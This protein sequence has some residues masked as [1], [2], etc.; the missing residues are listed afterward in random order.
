M[1]SIVANQTMK[2]YFAIA[3]LSCFSLAHLVDFSEWLL[4]HSILL[5]TESSGVSSELNRSSTAY[6][7]SSIR[8]IRDILHQRFT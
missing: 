4:L 7:K 6:I 5:E 1:Y 8:D 3:Q 2:G